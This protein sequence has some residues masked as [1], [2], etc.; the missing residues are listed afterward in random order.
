M[1]SLENSELII[2]E[3]LRLYDDPVLFNCKSGAEFLLRQLQPFQDNLKNLTTSYQ[4]YVENENEPNQKNNQNFSNLIKNLNIF[5]NLVAESVVSGKITSLTAGDLEQGEI[6]SD[7]CKNVGLISLR[8]LDKMKSA[9]GL[10][11]DDYE[12]RNLEE[13]MSKMMKILNDLLPKVHEISKEEIGD[14]V[15]QEMHNTTEAIEA[16][17]AK[18]EVHFKK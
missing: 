11:K 15:D 12:L 2:K 8:V 18:L 10:A 1:G 9:E 6:L 4:K 13:T 7:S 5:S 3:S 16:A 14:L 17:V